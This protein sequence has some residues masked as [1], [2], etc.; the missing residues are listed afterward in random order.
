M[1]SAELHDLGV[2]SF[3]LPVIGF[4]EGEL[5]DL[6]EI[7]LPGDGGGENPGTVTC[8]ECQHRFVPE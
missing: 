1:L 6:T 8:P 5:A 3:D 4:T 2:E 7:A